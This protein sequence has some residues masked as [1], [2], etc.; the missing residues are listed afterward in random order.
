MRTHVIIVSA[1]AL[2]SLACGST[3]GTALAPT[4]IEPTP[5]V[6]TYAI[7]IPDAQ[8]V[9]ELLTDHPNGVAMSPIQAQVTWD[10][11]SFY[12]VAN[13]YY[14]P[15]APN[16]T[17]AGTSPFSGTGIVVAPISVANTMRFTGAEWPVVAGGLPLSTTFTWLGRFVY[18]AR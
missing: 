12:G 16:L 5:I 4:P 15:N 13:V 7:N 11:T 17:A 18:V 1:I 6:I 8:L 2:L 10:Y 9:R 14:G 3:K